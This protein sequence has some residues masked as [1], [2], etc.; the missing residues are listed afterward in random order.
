[1]EIKAL[2]RASKNKEE[3]KPK[4]SKTR[5]NNHPFLK[6]LGKKSIREKV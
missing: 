3:I 1:L 5:P 4:P 6:F 2:F